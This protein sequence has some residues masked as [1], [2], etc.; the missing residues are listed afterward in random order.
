MGR[1][2]V[3]GISFIRHSISLAFFVQDTE[4]SWGVFQAGGAAF[5]A[6]YQIFPNSTTTSTNTCFGEHSPYVSTNATFK[7]AVIKFIHKRSLLSGQDRS[8]RMN[9]T[10]DSRILFFESSPLIK[11]ACRKDF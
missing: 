7:S 11:S 3:L 1:L 8:V 6:L 5:I 10:F 4:H 9:V 2:R